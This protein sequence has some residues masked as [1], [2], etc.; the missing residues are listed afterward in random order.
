M[1]GIDLG[2]ES[3]R[4]ALD[5]VDFHG[6]D[7]EDGRRLLESVRRAVVVPAVARSGLR[8]AAADQAIA[9]AWAAAWD[10][11]R[12]PSARRADNPIGMVWVAVRRA[13]GKE[14]SDHLSLDALLERGMQIAAG[15]AQH[16][17]G[18]LGFIVSQVLR[19]LAEVGW[20]PDLAAEA[21]VLLADSAVSRPGGE[22]AA[23]WRWVALRLGIPEWQMSRLAGLLL[24]GPG[25][26]GTLELAACHGTAVLDDP[27]VI[28]AVRSTAVHWMDSP[29]AQ[30]G[31]PKASD[32]ARL[33]PGDR[34]VA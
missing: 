17:V 9:S 22:A 6:W 7:S 33:T 3:V 28:A 20:P 27:R 2:P 5:G 14:V 1:A 21:V 23:R 19:R 12:R 13:I 10:A 15:Q 30:L 32:W 8:G 29:G 25:W 26:A 18:A 4:D 34:V 24:G 31:W 16:E 11:L